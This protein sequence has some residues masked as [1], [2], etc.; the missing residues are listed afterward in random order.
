MTGLSGAL[1][2]G[3]V[4]VVAGVCLVKSSQQGFAPPGGAHG[5]GWCGPLE[6]LG[7]DVVF[8]SLELADERGLVCAEWF[9]AASM[10]ENA[11]AVWNR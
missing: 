11:I 6:E 4:A 7:S 1:A 9:A 3:L 8:E 5:C 10:V 2:C